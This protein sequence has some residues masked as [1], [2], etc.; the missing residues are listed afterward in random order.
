M[1]KQGWEEPKKRKEEGKKSE[2][3]N[4]KERRSAK[5]NREGKRF[6]RTKKL[7]KRQTLC[8]PKVWGSAGEK[9][10]SVKKQVRSHVAG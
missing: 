7:K 3:R 4:Q 2:K 10:G 5:T 1:E 6:R 8:F 9:I